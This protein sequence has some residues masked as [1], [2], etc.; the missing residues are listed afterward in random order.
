MK[1]REKKRLRQ[2][3]WLLGALFL[4]LP[5][6]NLQAQY[7]YDPLSTV[8]EEP[9]TS[10]P[11]A[12]DAMDNPA[13]PPQQQAPLEPTVPDA[14]NQQADPE[15]SR[16]QDQA[17]ED[18][19]AGDAENPAVTQRFAQKD[20]TV[21][22]DFAEV[23]IRDVVKAISKIT[24]KNFI[25][26][27]RVRGKVTIISPA[28]VTVKEAYEAFLSAL[29]VKNFSVVEE[30][31]VTKILPIRE[32]KSS[33]IPS[34]PNSDLPYGAS[35][36]TRIIPI[37]YINANE[38][39]Q[40]LRSLVSPN[41]SIT[42]YGPTNSLIVT[43][44]ASNIRRLMKII[45][46]LDRRGFQEGIEVIPVTY[47]SASEMAKILNDLFKIDQ[48]N[49]NVPKRRS[50]RGSQDVEGG[51]IISKILPD[52]R[53]NSLIIVANREGVEKVL[54]VIR[55]LDHEMR[56]EEGKG[57]IHAHYLE[58]ADAEEMAST[59]SGLTGSGGGGSKKSKSSRNT[60]KSGAV[61]GGA[62]GDFPLP[63]SFPTAGKSSGSS[64]IDLFEGDVR[65]SPDSST[66]SL[67]IVASPQDYESLKPVIDKLDIRR[68]QVFVEA[69][70]LEVNLSKS[71][72][73]GVAGHGAQGFGAN[74]DNTLFGGT[75]F[76]ALNSLKDPISTAAA[77]GSGGLFGFRG[78][79]IDLGFGSIPLYGAVFRALQTDQIVNV[80]STPNILT[81]DNKPAEILVGQ[82]VAVPLQTSLDQKNQPITSFDRKDVGISLKV[83]PQVN[84]SNFITMDIEQTIEEVGPQDKLGQPSFSKRKA[85][86][87]VVVENEQTIVIGGLISD[88]ETE[89]KSKV[90][91]LGDVP[92]LGWLFQNKSKTKERKNLMIF[93]TPYI[94]GNSTDAQNITRDKDIQ[95]QR[96][97]RRNRMEE[98]SGYRDYGFD[99]RMHIQRQEKPADQGDSSGSGKK[100][101]QSRLNRVKSGYEAGTA[102]YIDGQV[103]DNRRSVPAAGGSGNSLS[104]PFEEIVPP[105]SE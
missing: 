51:Q 84:E 81:T 37:L 98:P 35:F 7:E 68:R 13:V 64:T 102:T 63:Q 48:K 29:E 40:S 97:N 57:R 44:S 92:L 104:S 17:N 74:N 99:K 24:G 26:D 75:T 87:S 71:L 82:N 2:W 31:K 6:L 69:I 38:I 28:K 59:L 50:T 101:G 55:R 60:T 49:A 33:A 61:P 21:Q 34:D 58:N 72:D 90:P 86:T 103:I 65:V 19:R 3:G 91:I 80:L 8:Q 56:L 12:P 15:D 46:K 94:V 16:V 52:D 76:G 83:T 89:T 47:A 79:N 41:G 14:N 23:E 43:D 45:T 54:A 62:G 39:V 4:G 25:L 22:L 18:L 105:S 27:D 30:G 42:A 20:A 95:R 66:N 88:S 77:A 96:F 73:V 53:T 78:K 1:M 36:I 85:Q 5:C 67:V 70:I 11:A 10:I 9:A 93:I 100:A 32:I